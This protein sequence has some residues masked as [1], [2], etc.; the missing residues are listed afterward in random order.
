M[1]IIL[2]NVKKKENMFPSF[3]IWHYGVIFTDIV[4]DADVLL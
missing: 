4:L 3:L 2:T 1:Q